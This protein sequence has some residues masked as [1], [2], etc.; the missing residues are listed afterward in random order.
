MILTGLLSQLPELPDNSSALKSFMT[1]ITPV[2]KKSQIC[3][4]G[5]MFETRY[6][7]VERT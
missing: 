2:T 1:M 3:L 6:T 4:K 5:D 7:S